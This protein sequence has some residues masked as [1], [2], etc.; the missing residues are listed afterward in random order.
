MIEAE[1]RKNM[2]K[3]PDAVSEI[4]N[5][6]HSK[7]ELG[8]SRNIRQINDLFCG[9]SDHWEY[10]NDVNSLINTV[11]DTGQYFIDNRGKNTPVFGN[12]INLVLKGIDEL[13]DTTVDQVREFLHHS[14]DTYN[15]K[16]LEKVEIIS[17]FGANLLMN[18]NSV[19]AYDYSSSVMAVLNKVADFGKKLHIIV[20]ESRDLDGGRPIVREATAKGHSVTYIIDFAFHNFMN[21]IDAVLIGAESFFSNGNCSTTVGSYPVAVFAKMHK[22]PV[23]V[24]TEL[25]K[26][27][28]R[29]YAG[30]LKPMQLDNYASMLGFP[31]KF[32]HPE[33]IEIEAPALDVVPAEYISAYITEK[34]V[35]PPGSIWATALDFLNSIDVS[36]VGE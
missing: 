8:A 26:I 3:L 2:P 9:I 32:A 33:L 23:Y 20:P 29:S 1:Y 28:S 31:G 25:I 5:K 7:D 12:A 13:A 10:P 14:R 22:V 19:M 16:S 30:L 17:T 36:P 21:K 35:M 11:K 34:G 27:D 24:P 18:A 6:L 4:V 15:Q